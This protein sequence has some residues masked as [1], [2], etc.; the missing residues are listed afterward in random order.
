MYRV[1]F[2]QYRTAEQI[3]WQKYHKQRSI[4]KGLTITRN[5]T[6]FKGCKQTNPIVL[7]DQLHQSA[8]S[9]LH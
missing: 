5:S 8:P 3:T 9:Y 7:P 6:S 1:V 4:F 2:G